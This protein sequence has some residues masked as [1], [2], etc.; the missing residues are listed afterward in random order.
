LRDFSFTA[1]K[2]HR[3][4]DEKA[5]GPQNG[6]PRSAYHVQPDNRGMDCGA[7]GIT[8]TARGPATGL[9]SVNPALGHGGNGPLICLKSIP[10]PA[11]TL[12]NAAAA[13]VRL[14]VWCKACT[15]QVEPDPAEM[16]RRY[17]A[18]ASV[19]DWREGLVCSRCGGR[20]GPERDQASLT[21]TSRHRSR[22]D[23][24]HFA[25]AISA[26]ASAKAR[27]GQRRGGLP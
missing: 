25:P 7:C 18:A 10:G 12:G 22:K 1:N 16:A 9:E 27:S 19:I 6:S 23:H 4:W 5:A 14:I 17:G 21:P 20:Q 2:A 24:E 3:H 13:Q 15:H 26:P 8:A 11:M